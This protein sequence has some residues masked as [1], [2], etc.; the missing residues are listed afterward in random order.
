MLLA[1]ASSAHS[2][3]LQDFGDNPGQLTAHLIKAD[4]GAAPLVLVLHGCEQDALTFA[5]QSGFETLAAVK[6]FNLLLPQQAKSNNIKRCFNWFSAQDTDKDS[7][8]MLSLKNMLLHAQQQTQS[9]AT[10]I[11][12]LSAGGAMASAMLAHYP[13]MFSSGAIVGGL[14]YPCA[15]SLTKAIS[16]MRTGPAVS[17]EQLAKQISPQPAT[18]ANWPS[19]SVWTG[20][21][22]KIVNPINA[23]VIAQQWAQL[24]QLQQ[25]LEETS[26]SGY[27]TQTWYQ[28]N[29]AVLQLVTIEKLGHGFPIDA[30]KQGGGT[31]AAFLLPSP[32]SAAIAITEFW[33]I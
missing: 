3:P 24:K 23:Q 26:T 32:I 16:C 9:Q 1:I 18:S 11:V 21:Q 33:Q 4:R 6:R 29:Q 20:S 22:D 10:Y 5:K 14:A 15:D 28:D 17:A 25:P 2:Q 13:E 31:A 19:L 27:Q 7:G 30:S 8:E 12:G